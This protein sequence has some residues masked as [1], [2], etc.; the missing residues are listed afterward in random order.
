MVPAVAPALVRALLSTCS[1]SVHNRKVYEEYIAARKPYI[2]VVWHKDFVFV[3]DWFRRKP[4]V[5]MVS[6]SKDGE[7]V[8]R[9][10]H[11]LGYRTVR[12]SS[13]TGG[14]EAFRELTA[15]LEE[16]WAAAII[17]DGPKGPARQSK[18]GP[19]M[20]SRDTGVPMIPFGCHMEPAWRMR[21]WDQTAIPKPGC[22]IAVAFGE[23][24][25]VPSGATR[26]ECEAIR[27]RLD[28]EMAELE[29]ICRRR[30]SRD[31]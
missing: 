23:P 28:R 24:I 25:V 1:V 3:L 16:G 2:G 19:I 31:A 18:L 11:R 21:N 26:P 5:V 10:L 27:D 15:K 20:A 12:G 13:S 6:R 22:R 9:T 17:A 29:A 7:L 14:G 4:I 8:A 30:T